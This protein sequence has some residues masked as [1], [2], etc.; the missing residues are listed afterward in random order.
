MDELIPTRFDNSGTNNLPLN[1]GWLLGKIN[2]RGR[3][4][5]HKIGE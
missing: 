1:C 4:H 2:V 5:I 3:K